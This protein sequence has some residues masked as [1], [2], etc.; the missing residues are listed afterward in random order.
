MRQLDHLQQLTNLSVL[1]NIVELSNI[2]IWS[3]TGFIRRSTNYT[4]R[5][6]FTR[7][8][9]IAWYKLSQG[10]SHQYPNSILQLKELL[11]S[12]LQPT[13]CQIHPTTQELKFQPATKHLPDSNLQPKTYLIPTFNQRLARFQ[14]AT[15]ALATFQPTTKELPDSNL[16]PKNL[17]DSN[18]QPKESTNIG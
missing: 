4:W 13:T 8:L 5:E 3:G 7:I 2:S 17:P 6:P 10:P 1:G 9:I 15:I 16:Q 11:D 14:P 12:N 18:K